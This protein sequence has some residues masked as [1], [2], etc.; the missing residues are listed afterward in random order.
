LRLGFRHKEKQNECFSRNYKSA[1]LKA[2]DNP[3]EIDII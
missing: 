3:R 1:I 2:I